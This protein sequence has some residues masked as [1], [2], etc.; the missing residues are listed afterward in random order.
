MGPA[1]WHAYLTRGKH[2]SGLLARWADSWIRA[3]RQTEHGK[4]AGVIPSVMRSHDGAYLIGAGSWD[5]PEAEWDYFQWRSDSQEGLTSLFLAVYDLTGERKYL[6][7]ATESFSACA[8]AT[9]RCEEIRKS[10][11]AFYAWRR[12]SRDSRYDGAFGYSSPSDAEIFATMTR[13]ARD[14][15]ERFSR[16]WDIFTAEVLYTDR[17]YYP[18]PAE[19][20]Q[21]LFGG[22][23]PRGDRYPTFAVTWPETSAEFARAVLDSS[24]TSLRLRLYGFDPDPK[25]IPVRLWRLKQGKYSWKAGANS[26]TF[27]VARKPHDLLL[28]LRSNQELTVEIGP[29]Q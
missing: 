28:P 18:L 20:R 17:V 25:Q 14:A 29:V 19:Y 12:V 21:F 4:P 13:Q 3:M 10:P 22:E 8:S 26:G 7:A 5:K 1:M 9:A 16:N 6:D 15:E 24:D 27:T 2:V 23:A 11:S